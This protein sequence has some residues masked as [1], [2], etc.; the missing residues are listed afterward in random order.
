MKTTGLAV[1]LVA[2]NLALTYCTT[3]AERPNLLWITAEDM[4]PVLGCNGDLY[5]DTPHLDQLA[6]ES[7]HFTNA[8]SS[9]PVC[10]PSRSTLITGVYSTSL[11]T[12]DLRSDFPL[13]AFVH[14]WPAL[15]RKAGY[16]T[17][18][19]SKTDYNTI[20]EERLIAEGWDENGAEAH[21]RNRKGKVPFF[22]VFNDMS[23]HQS[24]TGVW[25]RERFEKTIQSQLSS[26]RIHD[27]D[28]A[29]VPA[30]Y[31]DTPAVRRGIARFYDCVSVMDLNVGK[32]VA[33]LKED[34]LY[35][36][37]IIFFYSDHGS[38]MP[39]GKRCLYDSGMHVPLLIRFPKKYQH[40]APTKPGEQT[41][42]LVSFVD[43]PATVLSLL[44]ID[45]PEYSQGEA[46]LGSRQMKPR[47]YVFGARDRVD[48][49]YDRSRSVRDKQYLYIR[50]Y[51][52]DLSWSQPSTYSDFSEVQQT[53]A[54]LAL[55]GKLNEVQ[56]GYAG[57]TRLPEELYDVKKDPQ[58]LKNLVGDANFKPVVERM[59]IELR[60]WIR[61]TR[62]VGFIPPEEARIALQQHPSLFEWTRAA[63]TFPSNDLLAAAEV[64][65][66][67]S[68]RLEKQIK[69]LRH[70]DPSV[71]L[72]AI[73]GLQ[74]QTELPTTC[75]ESVRQ[76]TLDDKAMIRVESASLLKDPNLLAK[77]L[78]SEDEYLV[79]RASRALELLGPMANNQFATMQSTLEK[80][81][82]RPSG[83]I[84]LFIRFSLETALKKQGEEPD[85]PFTP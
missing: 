39:R 16:F 18:N 14:A 40:L 36:N 29:P 27:P 63:E 34:G 32:L 58:N 54:K 49:C 4:S 5:A 64:I 73:F 80:W 77:E 71:R 26:P 61:Q 22:S 70:E 19:N 33:Q 56:L 7:T 81:K 52:P 55:E 66:R 11:G 65:G 84:A 6:S 25:P 2:S 74:A 68:D 38:G 48:E 24:R 41:D 42:R 20:D 31:P 35:D 15:L 60:S 85:D 62:D 69:S 13:P 3:G 43:F 78:Q 50:N 46:F 76:A 75:I 8:F 28:K 1:L 21:W 72:M 12:Q 23:T 44:E 57:P 17:T 82:A 51:R 10:S 67:G 79:L 47:R 53:I 37:T 9:S 45:V 30:Y 83:P 59:R